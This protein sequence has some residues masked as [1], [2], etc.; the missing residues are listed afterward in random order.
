MY[1][2]IN[3]LNV[4]TNGTFNEYEHHGGETTNR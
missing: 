4:Y 1:H 2:S 3:G